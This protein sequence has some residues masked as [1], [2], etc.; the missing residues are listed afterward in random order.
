LE[1]E[2]KQAEESRRAAA[3]DKANNLF[4]V[5]P[6]SVFDR[7]AVRTRPAK[8]ARKPCEHHL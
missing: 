4:M 8:R 5:L 1:P 2:A 7:S 3:R 6:F